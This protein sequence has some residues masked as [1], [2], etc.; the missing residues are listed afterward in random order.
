VRFSD[1]H[2]FKIAIMR[3]AQQPMHVGMGK[4]GNSNTEFFF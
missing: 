4:P 3:T 2:N 1:T